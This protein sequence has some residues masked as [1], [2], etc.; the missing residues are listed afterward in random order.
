MRSMR[1]QPGYRTNGESTLATVER[2][3]Q[4]RVLR[5]SG[6]PRLML[7]LA[8]LGVVPGVLLTVV[9][10]SGPAIVSLGDAA[11]EATLLRQDLVGC[12]ARDNAFDWFNSV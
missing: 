10:P 6:R 3:S 12:F 7:R 2:G 5:V 11:N 1:R 4:V 8:T 9:K